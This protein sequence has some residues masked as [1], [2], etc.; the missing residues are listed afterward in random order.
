MTVTTAEIHGK[1]QITIPKAIRDHNGLTEGTKI[2]VIDLGD[3]RLLLEPVEGDAIRQINLS[4]NR[5]S[6]LLKRNGATL[7]SAL[8]A[9]RKIRENGE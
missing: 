6:Q 7:E 5:T 8:Q 4:F 1:G 3:G 9:L 2:T